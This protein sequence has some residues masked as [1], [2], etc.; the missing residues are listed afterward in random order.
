[1]EMRRKAFD[2]IEH[3]VKGHR[4]LDIGYS[5][6]DMLMEA[7]NRGYTDLFGI[8]VIPEAA[9]LA[10][11]RIG[12]GTYLHGDFLSLDL[13]VDFFDLIVFNYVLMYVG[14]LNNW[15]QKTLR[16]LRKGGVVYIGE[17]SVHDLVG[18]IQTPKPSQKMNVFSPESLRFLLERHNMTVVRLERVSALRGP[19]LAVAFPHRNVRRFAA[20][21]LGSTHIDTLLHAETGIVAI[22]QKTTDCAV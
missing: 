13:P 17:R 20:R 11:E 19:D 22:G 1:M 2:I 7:K 10:K 6:G 16:C 8:E 14:A 3:T 9:Q 5:T 4:I 15:M 18:R 21:L 12:A